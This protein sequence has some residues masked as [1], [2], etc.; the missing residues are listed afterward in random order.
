MKQSQ[1]EAEQAVVWAEYR[2]LLE[3]LDQSWPKRRPNVQLQHFPRL[4]RRL[5]GHY[6]LAR[7]RGYSPGLVN[8]LQELVHR[9]YRQLY[10]SQRDWLGGTL[11]FLSIGFPRTLRRHAWAFWL[12]VAIFFGPMLAMGLAS[13]GNSEAIYSILDAGQVAE[14]ESMYDPTNRK[15]GR[16]PERQ[17]NTDFAMFGFYVMNNV[18]VAFRTFAGGLFFGLG[19]LFFLGLNGL[20]VGG[21]A[22]HLSQLGYGE[23]F[24]PFVSGH[25]ALE[26]TAIAISGAAGLLLAAALF[27][28]GRR[29]RLDALRTNAA[30]AAK[31]IT[32]AMIMLVLAAIIEGFWSASPIATQF[33]YLFGGCWWLLVA[34]YLA[35]AGR[36]GGADAD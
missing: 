19:S 1:F 15:P 17:A 5:C 31:L 33:K 10:R 23:T 26:L 2:G 16:N 21:V 24:W 13:Y 32:G 12:S 6:A 29:R 25:G 27:A 7:S 4:F 35:L 20:V 30:E 36:R 18:G 22:G 3:A 8:E 28:P 14:M 11:A 9:G 34:L